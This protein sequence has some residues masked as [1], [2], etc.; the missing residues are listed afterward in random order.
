MAGKGVGV[1][2]TLPAGETCP[3]RPDFTALMGGGEADAGDGPTGVVGFYP[4]YNHSGNLAEHIQQ[5]PTAVARIQRCVGL[6]GGFSR[7]AEMIPTLN[8]W[9]QSLVTV[10]M[11]NRWR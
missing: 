7:L 1:G 3:P 2:S 9:L 8:R 5:R 11:G 4:G 10:P 6:A